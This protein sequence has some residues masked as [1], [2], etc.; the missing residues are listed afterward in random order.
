MPINLAPKQPP[1][2]QEAVRNS[3]NKHDFHRKGLLGTM[4]SIYFSF[5]CTT[6]KHERSNTS[7][8][9][10]IHKESFYKTEYF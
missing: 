2:S 10:L 9:I 3:Y 1:Y 8:D 6:V 5:F 7:Y 4:V